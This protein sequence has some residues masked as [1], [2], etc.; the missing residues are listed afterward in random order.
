METNF[1]EFA[2]VAAGTGMKDHATGGIPFVH[3]FSYHDPSSL[4]RRQIYCRPDSAFFINDSANIPSALRLDGNTTK[5][6]FDGSP[7]LYPV[8][9]CVKAS[10]QAGWRRVLFP[11]FSSFMAH[12]HPCMASP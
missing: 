8:R 3:L 7:V 4:G 6:A 12:F 9:G 1:C 5:P 11:A 10:M 2:G